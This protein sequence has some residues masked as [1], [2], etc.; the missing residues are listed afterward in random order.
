MIGLKISMKCDLPH[1]VLN[2]KKRFI[3]NTHL[4]KPQLITDTHKDLGLVKVPTL[5]PRETGQK[6]GRMNGWTDGRM[7][8]H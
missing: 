1:S 2:I 5:H 8:G 3:A 6:D 4:S 7:D